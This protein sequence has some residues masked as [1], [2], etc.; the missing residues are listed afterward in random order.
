MK[1]SNIKQ[2]VIV[3]RDYDINWNQ[4]INPI[5]VGVESGILSLLAHKK[6]I[7]FVCGD[8]DTITK[9]QLKFINKQSQHNDF[10]IITF[11][12]EKDFID[13]ELAIIIAINKNIDFQQIVIVADGWRWDM[14]L[15]SINLLK[16][17]QSFN[18]ILLGNNNYCFLL[19][20]KTEYIFSDWQLTYKYISFF[21]LDGEEVIYNFSGC[22]FYPNQ[23][24]IVTSNSTQAISNEFNQQEIAKLTIKK[25]HC[26]IFLSK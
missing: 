10:D 19:Q 21:S 16:K 3:C 26:L 8:H 18:P 24:I 2:L 1:N 9:Q 6:P 5:F 7:N 15:T 14:L 23:D 11:T 13:S 12:K 25:G 17:Y 20:A 4:F 22:K